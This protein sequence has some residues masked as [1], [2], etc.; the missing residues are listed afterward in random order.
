MHQE[1]ENSNSNPAPIFHFLTHKAGMDSIDP[2]KVSQIVLETSKNSEFYK[3]QQEKTQKYDEKIR[4]MQKTIDHYNGTT[5]IEIEGGLLFDRE[6][7]LI[8]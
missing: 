6:G 4:E 8:K 5:K 1:N 2:Q 3:R 7:R